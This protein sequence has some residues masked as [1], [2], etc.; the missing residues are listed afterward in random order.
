MTEF[1]KDDFVSSLQG[2]LKS[3][4]PDTNVAVRSIE[5]DFSCLIN[6]Y[7]PR[8]KVNPSRVS[9]E[10]NIDCPLGELGLIDI[11]N[12]RERTYR[13]AT[14]LASAI[15]PWIALAIIV[16]QANGRN[17][18]KLNELLMA[19]CNIGKIFN[20]DAVSMLDL[21][22]K[23]EQLSLIKIN[24]AA[25]SDVITIMQELSFEE[26]VTAYYNSL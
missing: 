17:E 9:A 7:L 4:E 26:C 18:I 10:N 14:P 12:R 1:S 22:Y 6:T 5:D 16:D 21:L 23:V 3:T 8:Y 19:P 24:R 25:G 20:L 11:V 13:R 15:D 2:Y